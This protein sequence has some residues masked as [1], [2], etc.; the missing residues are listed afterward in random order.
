MKT[1]VSFS[2]VERD[3]RL[4]EW[5]AATGINA[6]SLD[7]AQRAVIFAAL[8]VLAFAGPKVIALRRM[9]AYLLSHCGVGIEFHD[10]RRGG[11]HDRPRGTQGP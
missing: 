3:T 2:E 8:T 4:V 6:A 7:S 1:P 9:V 10:R 5:S 11:R